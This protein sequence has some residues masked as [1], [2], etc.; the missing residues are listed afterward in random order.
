MSDSVWFIISGIILLAVGAVFI[1][2]GW[3]I[4]NKQKISLVHDYQYNRVS[5][6]NKPAF[7]RKI[8]IGMTVI[9]TGMLITG[10]VTM[11]TGSLLS[12]IPLAAGLAVGTFLMFSAIT[13]YNR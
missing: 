6:E 1:G 9:G 5:D 7:C 3:A 8:G 13:K 4:W 10:I 11:L 2:L 12:L